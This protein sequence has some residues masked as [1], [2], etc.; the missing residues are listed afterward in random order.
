MKK[1]AKAQVLTLP[2]LWS[3]GPEHWQSRWERGDDAFERVEQD[4]WETPRLSDWVARLDATLRG[5]SGPVVL[6]AHS[7]GCILAADWAQRARLTE[8]AKVIG[9]LLVAPADSERASFPL[10]PTGFAPLPM[11]VIA[12]PTIVVASKN[13][14]FVTFDRSASFAK[15][16]GSQLHDAGMSGHLNAASGHGP[17]PE[18]RALLEH[19]REGRR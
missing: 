2:G 16:W 8:R 1:P 17:W 15:A 7:A 4:E 19:L 13:D 5:R 10:G 12:F 18:G 11:S 3:S 6:A 14:P 9:V